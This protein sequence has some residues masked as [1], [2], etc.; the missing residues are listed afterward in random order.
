MIKRNFCSVVA[1]ISCSSLFFLLSNTDVR[2]Q[3]TDYRR[4]A[5]LLT[6]KIF[7]KHFNPRPLD[8]DFSENVWET[9]FHT[10][11]PEGLY[12][13]EADLVPVKLF[14]HKL[15]DELR[16][17]SW[18]FV[19]AVTN[20]YK[21]SLARSEAL[22]T[23]LLSKPLSFAAGGDSIW[24]DEPARAKD[25]G[26]NEAYWV[27]WVK[28]KT[29]DRV[30]A[31]AL[32]EGVTG[33]AQQ[34]LSRFGVQ[35]QKQVLAAVLRSIQKASAGRHGIEAYIG[36]RYLQSIAA[37]FDAHTRYISANAFEDFISAISAEGLSF[38]LG[39]EENERG[40]I[41]IE[42]LV[43]GGPAWKSGELN[44]SDVLVRLR[45]GSD[46]VTELYGLGLD[47]V[48]DLI[49]EVN[50]T[51]V[52]FTVRKT[53]GR[54]VTVKLRKEQIALED[55]VVRSFLLR[56]Q[57]TIGFISLPGFY[58]DFRSGAGGRHSASD[59]A[60]EIVKLKREGIEGLILD[61]RFNGGGSLKEAMDL[62]GIFIDQGALAISKDR[63]GNLN[64]LKDAYR[65]T[66]YDGPLLVLT[67]RLS[68]SASEFL[69]AALQDHHRAI[70]FGSP[71]YGKATAQQII[72]VNP[73]A[74]TLE[75]GLTKKSG[76][77][78]VIL[79]TQ[80][81]YRVTGLTAQKQGVRPDIYVPDILEAL[82]IYESSQQLALPADSVQKKVY[83]YPSAPLPLAELKRRSEARTDTST[84]FKRI[85]D[86]TLLLRLTMAGG[87]RIPLSWNEFAASRTDTKDVKVLT[88]LVDDF[89][90]PY[91][92]GNHALDAKRM[93][94][95]NFMRDLN[96]YWLEN[97]TTDVYLAEAFLVMADYLELIKQ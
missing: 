31:L 1:V 75:D 88:K 92:V 32:Q 12:I 20:M 24:L 8:D 80:K 11:D 25:A 15:D 69:A 26:A 30:Y 76:N 7:E 58:T 89:R 46:P 86:L 61:V 42:H 64:T 3:T 50:Q 17:N 23:R 65:G 52:E 71:T 38:G 60:Q 90:A 39:L 93:E 70:I 37:A 44:T 84:I 94:V 82:D 47:D 10:L 66:V 74:N 40:E 97:L 79:T 53:G 48:D 78:F 27:R 29:L 2:A 18:L 41:V 34:I 87:E 13:T 36:D 54:I 56:G 9:F 57:K 95:D 16:T 91:K 73:S 19:P 59:V 55:N 49:D 83:Y 62:A 77:G 5:Q 35:A 33:S 85:S 67:N 68:A 14:E 28:Y 81:T 51:E 4:E 96:G 72:P 45:V 22:A 21:A 6:K 43:P 63:D